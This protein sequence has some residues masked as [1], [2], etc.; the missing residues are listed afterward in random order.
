MIIIYTLLVLIIFICGLAIG[1]IVLYNKLQ[2]YTTKVDQAESII[3][4]TLRKRYDLAI[5]AANI[6]EKSIKDK[7]KVFKDLRS[8]KDLSIS[9]FDFDR[10]L[11][12]N[13]ELIKQIRFDYDELKDNKEL[14]TIINELKNTSEKLE[15]AKS[16]YNKYTNVLN[17]LIRKFPANIIA[18]M[19]NI[20]IRLFF[21]G[22]DMHDDIVDDFK[23]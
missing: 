21:D 23:L 11:N 16:F 8:Y 10:K 18:K 4:D 6:I 19:H 22:K 2:H 12:E 17:D 14:K 3:D 7:K 5:N 1:Y 13:V 20:E 9:T 15:A